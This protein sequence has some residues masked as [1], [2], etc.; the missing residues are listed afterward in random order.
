MAGSWRRRGSRISLG[1]CGRTSVYH[2][3]RRLRFAGQG[4]AGGAGVGAG[5]LRCSGV[6][7]DSRAVPPGSLFVAL[8]G[9]KHDAHAFVAQA[10]ANG[11]AGAVVERVP[12]NCAWALDPLAEGPPLILVPSATDALA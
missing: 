3:R 7:I 11:A 4:E 1:N 9:Q 5:D 12:A 10:L 2:R 6:A 8:K